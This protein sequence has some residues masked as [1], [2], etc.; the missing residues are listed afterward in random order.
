MAKLVI[1]SFDGHEINDG[2]NYEA[3]FA[4]ANPWGHPRLEARMSRR[5]GAW[6]VITNIDRRQYSLNVLIAVKAADVD[7]A[8]DD[9]LEWLF[10]KDGKPRR[11][12]ITDDGGGNERYVEALC[13][14][15]KP[16]VKNP[17]T[18][19][20]LFT[21]TF[22][23]SG[24]V[25]WR[26]TSITTDT[27]NITG[28]PE[29]HTISNG[30]KEEAY[31]IYRITPTSSK[32]SS[33]GPYKRYIS[34][35]WNSPELAWRYPI[36]LGPFDTQTGSTNF[37]Q[38]DGS[39]IRIFAGGAE[40]DRYIVDPNTASTYIWVALNF[41]AQ[42]EGTLNVTLP[43][44][45]TIAY[46]ETE[47]PIDD[48]PSSGILRIGSEEFRYT[49][50][51][52]YLQRVT[53]ISRA[54]R[55][56][57]EAAHAIGDTIDLIPHDIIMTYGSASPE[58]PLS[59]D[60]HE[61]MFDTASSTNTLWKYVNFGELGRLQQ[62]VSRP[63]SW[64]SVPEVD[65]YD[66]AGAYNNVQ[67][68]FKLR[69]EFPYIGLYIDDAVSYYLWFVSCPGGIINAEW[70]TE[71]VDGEY[72]RGGEDFLAYL[73]RYSLGDGRQT[74]IREFT[75]ADIS[76]VDTWETWTQSKDGTDWD[77]PA[78]SVS[79]LLYFYDSEIAAAHVNL[80]LSSTHTP[81]VTVNSGSGSE[82]VGNYQLN[83]T[84]KNFDLGDT[85]AVVAV[86]TGNETITIEGEH[87]EE[88]A[89]GVVFEVEGSTGNDGIYTVSAV[90]YDEPNDQTTVTVTGD[91]T[92]ATADGNLKPGL[93]IKIVTEIDLNGTV[94]I[95]T[96]QK[97]VTYLEDGSS[98]F[99][100]LS[101]P[102][103]VRND[104][105]PLAS[106][107]NRLRFEDSGTAGLTIETR[108]RKRWY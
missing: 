15:L 7:A 54:V 88:F 16:E 19:D 106:G 102:E 43:S 50:K 57:A 101:Y 108:Y 99:G 1:K 71:G 41:S 64:K 67:R 56:T 68:T 61:P 49:G 60:D 80:Y 104:W 10:P 44:A 32:S 39:D 93:S 78:G 103:G 52:T 91:I 59:R 62:L 20:N 98:Q 95:D 21:A 31:P 37:T 38:A 17:F 29:T 12:V 65:T 92:E 87:L 77:P 89:V 23:V 73:R 14:D 82:E 58:T 85:Y 30:G 84:L 81:T 70:N 45:G 34:I 76:S 53:G 6:P 79:M 26:A 42:V 96:A 18:F 107:D 51:D 72:R 24:D 35:V 83:M 28:S 11:L 4:P 63:A 97:T 25:R 2:T 13:V 36:R 27:W 90:S 94:E 48:W 100:A 74:T 86:D 33:A 105:L 46:I 9:L 66:S 8:R 47:D 40:L 22:V 55:N 69:G 5:E 3:T 75:E